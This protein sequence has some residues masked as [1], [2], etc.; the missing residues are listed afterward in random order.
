MSDKPRE[1]ELKRDTE[2]QYAD[3]VPADIIVACGRS[4]D[5]PGFEHGRKIK[6]IE[7]SAYDQLL[8]DARDLVAMLRLA[9]QAIWCENIDQEN[10][11]YENAREAIAAFEKK[12]GGK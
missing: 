7:K 12:W 1:W 10:D 3:G 4:W 9:K 2:F 5:W 6:V 8:K 11:A